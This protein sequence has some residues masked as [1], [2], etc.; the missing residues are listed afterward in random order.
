MDS[1]R[2][3]FIGA[4]RQQGY[5]DEVIN[6]VLTKKGYQPISR[7]ESFIMGPTIPVAGAA[8]GGV[9]GAAT[10]FTPVGGAAIGA[11][12]GYALRNTLADI[13]GYQTQAPGQQLLQA[14]TGMAT[15]GVGAGLLASLGGLIAPLIKMARLEP[16]I[17]KLSQQRGG[18]LAKQEPMPFAA[19]EQDI[20]ELVPQ[21]K[22]IY[23]K[24]YTPQQV[25]QATKNY[26]ESLKPRTTLVSAPPS[27]EVRTIG[28]PTIQDIISS[29][30]V[31]EYARTDLRSRTAA[32]SA[33][34]LREYYTKQIPEIADINKQ[35]QQLIAMR[36]TAQAMKAGAVST[37]TRAPIWIGLGALGA[38]LRSKMAG[39]EE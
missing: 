4:A 12:G 5:S 27:G 16:S 36:P 26:L 33:D 25:T 9:A 39:G 23:G 8:L 7:L 13:L 31:G 2:T 14:G 6:E 17:T 28:Y 15:A 38:W 30:D 29:A 24:G 20:P 19:L 34:V 3:K 21:A 22:Q 37:L 18:I 11:G 35:L 1:K 10:P 32:A